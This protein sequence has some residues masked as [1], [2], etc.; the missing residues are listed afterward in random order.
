MTGAAPR[1]ADVAAAAGVSLATA[2]RS[3]TGREGVSDAVA[4]RVRET[5]LSL[6]YVPNVH[7]RSLAV[8]STSGIGLIVHEIDDPYFA[9]I[10]GAVVHRAAE[11]ELMVQ[12]CHSG[13]D[14]ETELRQLRSLIANRVRGVIIAGSGYVGPP[15]EVDRRAAEVLARYGDNGG[16]VAVIG[17]HELDADAV[18]PA[19]E[20]GGRAAAEHLRQLGHRRVAV[21]AGPAS[22]TTVEDRLAGIRSVFGEAMVVVRADFT[23]QGGRTATATVVAEHPDV[24]A[25]MALNDAMA[26]GVLSELRDAGTAVPEAM[27]VVGFDDVSVASSL[28]PALTTVRL[29]MAEMGRAALAMV[30]EPP[31]AKPRRTRVDAELVVRAS[32]AAPRS[33]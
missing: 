30:L 27:S 25:I 31:S 16:R 15:G 20:A 9:E 5:A 13:R 8:G 6:G 2:S 14:P 26:I 32:T 12:I 19:N 11:S 3:L 23:G 21:A 29:P 22:L 18:L 17:R 33:P 24:T 4:A 1:L 10:A 28:A 7:A